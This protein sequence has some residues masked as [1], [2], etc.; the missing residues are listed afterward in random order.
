M[1]FIK[2]HALK[3]RNLQYAKTGHFIIALLL[4]E[5]F[6]HALKIDTAIDTPNLGKYGDYALLKS[7]V[8]NQAFDYS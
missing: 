3:R 1:H 4:S 7:Y 8:R 6:K 2:S 5:I